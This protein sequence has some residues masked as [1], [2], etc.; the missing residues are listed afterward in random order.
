MQVHITKISLLG[1]LWTILPTQKAPSLSILIGRLSKHS[2]DRT[3]NVSWKCNLMF[4]QSFLS[5][6]KSSFLQNVFYLS[7]NWIGTSASEVRMHD[8]CHHVLKWSTQLQN[9]SFHIIE[10]TRTSV[11]CPKIKNAHAKC[12]KLLFFLIKFPNLWLS[13]CSIINMVA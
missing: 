2:L 8:I 13:C 7:W 5:D 11:K 6:S 12:A 10:K 1:L 9:R 4:L 3:E